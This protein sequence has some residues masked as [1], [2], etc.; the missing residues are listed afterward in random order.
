MTWL[1]RIQVAVDKI[2]AGHL[3][4]G[5]T[6]SVKGL[7]GFQRDM[8]EFRKYF[9]RFAW[10]VKDE[11]ESPE[12]WVKEIEALAETARKAAGVR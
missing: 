7:A 4:G 6:V 9:R 12:E 1:N 2:P 11:D 5:P 10:A 3:D 8:Q